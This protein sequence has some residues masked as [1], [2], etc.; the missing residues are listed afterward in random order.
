MRQFKSG[1][2]HDLPG[3]ANKRTRLSQFPDD[4][5]V[6]MKL[7]GLGS[8]GCNMIEGAPFPTV[9]FSTS[10]ADIARS[11]ADRKILL[12]QDRL[13]GAAHSGHSI[14]KRLPEIAGHEV[15]DLFNNTDLAFLMC[16]LGGVSG[17]IG[18]K[19]FTSV[20]QSRG[21]VD[22]VLA[23]VPFSAESERRRELAMSMLREL[24]RTSALCIEFSNDKLSDLAPNMP[25]SRAFGLMN[26]IMLRPVMDMIST[27]SRSDMGLLRQVVGNATSGRF[28]LGL[29]RG[30]DRVE[31]TVKEALSSPW[32]DFD[33][34]QVPS[35]IAVYSS[36]D[37]WEAEIG[38]VLSGLEARLPNA[39]ILWGS[40]QDVALGDRIRLSLVLCNR[41]AT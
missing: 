37:P 22:I 13:I 16:G 9:A 6:R 19:L 23:A 33:L 15:V 34:G 12:G 32:F 38:K 17:S 41:P 36:A 26:G 21:T 18:A 28:G 40:Y 11:H 39:G 27:V 5:P 20:A 25:M 2:G 3:M 29:A 8:A 31:R 24:H 14:L 4:Q 1:Y 35:A 30:D 10:S 7:F